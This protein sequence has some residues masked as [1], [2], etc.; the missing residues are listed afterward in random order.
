[1]TV[2][3]GYRHRI[4]FVDVWINLVQGNVE[5]LSRQA[6]RGRSYK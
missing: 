6:L 4:L 5:E 3:M 2:S 1:M